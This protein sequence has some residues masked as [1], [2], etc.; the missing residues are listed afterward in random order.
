MEDMQQRVTANPDKVKVR[1][2]L[3]GHPFGTIQRWM[4]QGYF[5]TRGLENVRGEMSLT[6]LVYNLKRGITIIGV[7]DL[8]AAVS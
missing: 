5:L 7:R 1:K 2:S 3:V 4:D 6:V 8:I